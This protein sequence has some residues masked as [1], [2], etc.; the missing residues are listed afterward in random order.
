[1]KTLIVTH[2]LIFFSTTLQANCN[3]LPSRTIYSKS[4]N[5]TRRPLAILVHGLNLLPSKMNELAIFSEQIGFAPIVISLM[6]HDQAE[7]ENWDKLESLDWQDQ[8][9]ELGSW[10]KS[11]SRPWV[12]ISQSTGSTMLFW[13]Q[14]NKLSP[15]AIAN[16]SFAPALFTK[17]PLAPLAF[18]AKFFPTFKIESRNLEDY[19]VHS[20][21]TL[22]TYRALHESSQ[23]FLKGD[24]TFLSN[25]L[26]LIISNDDELLDVNDTEA[27]ARNLKAKVLKI[28]P[29]PSDERAIHHLLIDEAR[30][31]ASAIDEIRNFIKQGLTGII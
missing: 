15:P 1:M 2:L 24:Q 28:V 9:K 10:L 23:N 25:K 27:W 7:K 8:M 14:Q 21:T 13:M 20:Y 12:S 29:K 6:G 16:I 4:F 31:G 22:S 5:D 19:R 17:Y 3:Q 11:C 26:L 18:F 30:A